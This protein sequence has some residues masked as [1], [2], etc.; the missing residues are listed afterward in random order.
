ML[1]IATA[2]E[3][4]ARDLLGLLDYDER[5]DVSSSAA[6]PGV[7]MAGV[8]H[9]LLFEELLKRAPTALAVAGEALEVGS[10]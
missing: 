7:A 1:L 9:F 3:A 10:S 8:L 4:R 6:I 2:G 5:L